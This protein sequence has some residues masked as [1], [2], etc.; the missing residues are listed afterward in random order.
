VLDT[1][2]ERYLGEGREAYR[3][4]DLATAERALSVALELGAADYA[5]VHHLLGVVYHAWGQYGKARAAFENA[6][7]INPHYSEAA[8]SLSIT[9]NDLGRYADAQAVLSR[10][11]RA[12]DSVGTD[13]LTRAKIANLHAAV[14]DAYRSA[15]M[16]SEAVIEFRRALALAPRFVDIRLRLA[17]ALEESGDTDAAIEELRRAREDNPRYVPALLLL[18]LLLHT[19][20]ELVGAKE[21]LES[22]LEVRPGHARAESY[23]RMLEPSSRSE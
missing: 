17:Q 13:A 18:G 12:D 3:R 16:P 1:E 4:G 5:D 10:V 15:R 6:L 2:L 11:P 21:A 14:G 20:G 7:R 23:L 9:Y 19:A 22:V 8:L